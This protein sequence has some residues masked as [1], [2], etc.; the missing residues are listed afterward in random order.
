M[1]HSTHEP[2]G[3]VRRPCMACRLNPIPNPRS[4]T[5]TSVR[6]RCRWPTSRQRQACKLPTLPSACSSL[7]PVYST[8]WSRIPLPTYARLS[9][10]RCIPSARCLTLLS[11]QCRL[12]TKADCRDQPLQFLH[13]PIAFDHNR[14]EHIFR[15]DYRLAR[16]P[17]LHRARHGSEFLVEELYIVITLEGSGLRLEARFWDEQHTRSSCK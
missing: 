17:R 2:W 7:R 4:R 14:K 12:S 10:H 6:G 1:K 11:L 13:H 5:S 15:S 9:I 16:A 3:H 8:L